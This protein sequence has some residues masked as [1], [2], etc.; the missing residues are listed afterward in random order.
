MKPTILVTG[1]TGKTGAAVVA[2][3]RENDW[4]VRAIV[5]RRDQRSEKLDRLG[6]QGSLMR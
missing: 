4:P 3:L 5:R 6:A 2:Q 1:A